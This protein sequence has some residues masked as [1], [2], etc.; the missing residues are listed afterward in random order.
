MK[1]IVVIFTCI[2]L[3][4]CITFGGVVDFTSPAW[5]I[6]EEIDNVTVTSTTTSVDDLDR[7]ETTYVVE[8]A[9]DQSI[10]LAG[11]FFHRFEMQMSDSLNASY[12]IYWAVAE[13]EGDRA[14]IVGRS[15][16]FVFIR[17]TNILGVLG[18]GIF[19]VEDGSF[20]VND[21]MTVTTGV[22]YYVTV[23]RDDDGGANSTGQYTVWVRTG[24]HIGTLVD[25]LTVDA[26][27]GEQN[28][29]SYIYSLMGVGDAGGGAT[30]D[31]FTQNMDLATTDITSHLL[32][33]RNQ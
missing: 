24:S 16:D 31:G 14:A 27:A 12:I 7:D 9:A 8:A 13:S 30:A 20:V 10:S 33:V 22:T 32:R 19:T 28:D 29:Y 18:L 2:L 11:D 3:F 17:I 25:T 23:Y 15:E 6:V 1:R 21:T 5:T 4:A 26:S